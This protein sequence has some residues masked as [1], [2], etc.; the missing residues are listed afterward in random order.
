MMGGAC[1]SDRRDDKP[2][3]S[4]VGEATD[5]I[6]VLYILISKFLQRRWEGKK[7]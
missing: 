6:I 3:H 1:R 5:K 2:K 4:S 7:F